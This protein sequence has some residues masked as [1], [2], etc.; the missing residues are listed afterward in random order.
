M[1]NSLFESIFS[2]NII[3]GFNSFLMYKYL[4]SKISL[5]L[6][7]GSC[8]GYILL[9]SLSKYIKGNLIY[10]FNIFRVFFNVLLTSNSI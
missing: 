3:L 9:L 7:D 4:P 5:N 8:P 2:P 10:L 6:I 1:H